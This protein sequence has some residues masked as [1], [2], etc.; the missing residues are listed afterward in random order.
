M[1]IRT[2]M[3]VAAASPHV[4]PSGARAG[5]SRS[6]PGSCDASPHNSRPP[7]RRNSRQANAHLQHLHEHLG[8]LQTIADAEVESSFTPPVVHRGRNSR[9]RDKSLERDGR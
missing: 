5:M 8:Q 2:S 1:D 6:Q 3:E 9:E 4:S 7:S